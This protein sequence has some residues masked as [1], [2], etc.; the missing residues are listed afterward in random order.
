MARK[1]KP[2]LSGGKLQEETAKAKSLKKFMCRE[3][4]DLIMLC[5]GG[6]TPLEGF[7]GQEDWRSGE[8]RMAVG[9]FWPIPITLSASKEKADSISIGEEVALV[10]YES[11]E[12][13]GSMVVEKNTI[14]KAYECRRFLKPKMSSIP[15]SRK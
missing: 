13:M 7:M 15:V 1:I 5:I 10:N 8:L 2:L 9:T 14:D 11:G 12:L 3:T 6:F 4:G